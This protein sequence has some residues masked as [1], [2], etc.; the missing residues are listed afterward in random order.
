MCHGPQGRGDGMA[1]ESLNPKPRNYGDQAWQA[2][3]TDAE[4]ATAIVKGGQAV[5]KSATM[6]GNPDLAAKPEVVAALV[7]LIRGFG[8]P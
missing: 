3:V 8:K 5:G 6:P 2:S 7:A 4:I 1:A